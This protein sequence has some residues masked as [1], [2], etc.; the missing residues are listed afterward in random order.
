MTSRIRRLSRAVVDRIAAGE[1]V[2]RP[3]SV[4]KELVENSLDAGAT[5]VDVEIRDGGRELI[6]V[7]DDG[8]GMSAEDLELALASHATS[9][10]SEVEDLDHIAS[11]G[12]RGEA[13]ASISA[14]ADCRILSR[15]TASHEGHEVVCRGGTADPVAVAAAPPGTLIEVRHLFKYVPAR[16]KFLRGAGTE[17]AHVAAVL[18]RIALAHPGVGF[19]FVRDGRRAFRVG[20]EDGRLERLARFHGRDLAGALLHV[21]AADGDL[22]LSGHV[23]RPEVAQR[24]AQNQHLFLNGRPIRDRSVAH[25]VRHA[26]EGLLTVGRNPVWFLF[27]ECDPAE[28]DVNV[29]PAKVEVR[30]R[31]GERIHRLV[32]RA[33]RETL[34]AADLSPNLL[35]PAAAPDAA[36][37]RYLAGVGEALAGFLVSN[38]PGSAPVREFPASSPHPVPAAAAPAEPSLPHMPAPRAVGRFLQVANM[39]LV[40]ETAD[41]GVAIADQH[42][43]HERVRLEEIRERVERGSLEV[44]RLLVP[45]LVELPAA[46]V[47]L[48]VDHAEDLLRVGVEV[49]RF[50]ETELA[51][52]SLPSMLPGDDPAGHLVHIAERLREGRS[53]GGRADLLETLLHSMA[54]RGAIFAGDPLTESQAAELLRRADLLE[55]PHSCAHGRP[56]VLKIPFTDLLRHFER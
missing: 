30:F 56:T 51:V 3:A 21:H 24:T 8:C 4:V 10:L 42:A 25:A 20:G 2:E 35:R 36:R 44:Q 55:N 1:V 48:V 41:G 11:F 19:S 34:L 45:A 9:K 14:V 26:F 53:T 39:F 18:H 6:A 15:E 37:D 12:F 33:V 17:S 5:R 28:V 13:L 40:F 46:D 49:T 54:C 38:P 43:L 29:H 7:R 47:D 22:R 50:G 27:L 31:D 52:H 32:R 23:G 16:R